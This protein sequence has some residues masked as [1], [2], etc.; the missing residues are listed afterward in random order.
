MS[1]QQLVRQ[2][3]HYQR[4][5]QDKHATN[6]KNFQA[7]NILMDYFDS[8][9]DSVKKIVAKKLKALGL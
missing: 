4:D 1:R 8:I 9:P 2:I 6:L 7:Y 5:L 3:E